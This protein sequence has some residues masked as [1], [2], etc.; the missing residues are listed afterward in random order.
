MCV[1][2]CVCVFM[3]VLCMYIYIIIESRYVHIYIY[4]CIYRYVTSV[5]SFQ[6]TLFILLRRT[7]HYKTL[8]Q[9][10]PLHWETFCVILDP[11]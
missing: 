9:H 4:V 1:C 3:C 5:Q 11:F 2:V 8:S 6:Q 7:H 10:F